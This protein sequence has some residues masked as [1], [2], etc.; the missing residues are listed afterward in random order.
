M[1]TRSTIVQQHTTQLEMKT[2]A[3]IGLMTACVSIASVLAVQA[4]AIALWPEIA[5]FKPLDSYARSA[6]FTF[7]PI[8][9]ATAVF[10]WLVN[11]KEQ[12]IP[13]FITVSLVVLLI[14]IIPDYVLPVPDKTVLA[15]SVTAFMH[16]V[17]GVTAVT[18][19]IAGY[20]RQ[21]KQ[22]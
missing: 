14:S 22:Q 4:V 12:P 21:L 16:V 18:L 7:I 9:G 20:R 17:A 15:S 10:A 2:W 6:L 3:K 8:M 11:R 5:L 1:T 13:K 19:L